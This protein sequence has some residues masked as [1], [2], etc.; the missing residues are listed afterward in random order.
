MRR[1]GGLFPRIVSFENLVLSFHRASKGKRYRPGVMRFF[2]DL[3]GELLLLQRELV[4]GEYRPGPFARFVIF[5]PKEREISVPPFR[6]R[7]VH[8]AIVGVLEPILEARFDPDSYGCRKGLG[9]DR[10]L[11]RARH[12]ASRSDFCLR[13][14][15]R[16]FFPSV[17]HDTLRDQL[18]G[19]LKD[20][21]LLALLDRI[22]GGGGP[23]LP[24]GS[25]TSQ[26]FANLYLTP[27]DRYL[28]TLPGVTGQ[29]RYMDDVLAFGPDREALHEALRRVR[30]F[31]ADRLR[32]EL[33]PGATRVTPTAPGVPFL[34]FRVRRSGIEV[35]R[36]TF[37]RFRDGMRRAESAWRKGRI[38]TDAL[39]DSV[40]SRIAH[41]GRGRS[42]GLLRAHFAR[43]PPLQW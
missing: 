22:I 9:M 32:L 36:E 40:T 23:G 35:R 3:E 30:T 14:D 38:D 25:L 6:D 5:D 29:V 12:H 1:V 19:I 28:R 41:L 34:G 8:H 21:V 15:V 11:A 16:K 4:S 37:R 33:K 2:R 39:S 43:A 20:R 18:R 31:V 7:V 17:D 10:A 24:I 42:Q 26:W 13:T 27:L